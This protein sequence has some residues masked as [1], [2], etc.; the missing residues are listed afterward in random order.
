MKFTIDF[1]LGFAHPGTKLV[2]LSPGY[3]RTW[4]I[5]A[6]VRQLVAP[7][8]RVRMLAVRLLGVTLGVTIT[9]ECVTPLTPPAG[10]S[11]ASSSAGAVQGASQQIQL[12]P[13]LMAQIQAHMQKQQPP[14]QASQSSTPGA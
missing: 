6:I 4:F 9:R 11:L 10:S 13:D 2:R 3:P 12:S 1:M 8:G 5:H 14:S 7:D